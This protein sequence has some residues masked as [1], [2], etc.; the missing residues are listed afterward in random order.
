MVKKLLKFLG[1]SLFFILALMA[2]IPKESV[3]FLLEKELKN[4]EVVI[5]KESLQ[6]NLFSLDITNLEVSAKGIDSAL[7]QEAQI[8]LLLLS[9]TVELSNIKLSS[10]VESYLPSK[11][12]YFQ[13]NYSVLNPFNVT[14]VSHGGFGE[15]EASFDLSSGALE[16]RLK[17]SKKMLNS[18]RSSL[19]KFKKSDNGEY[20]YAKT[21]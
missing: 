12:E 1:L 5:S 20:V 4:F 19:R 15:A 13:A 16:V 6:E 8:T 21:F 17:P 18:Y 9:N 10:L 2:F 7:V 11:I 3:Y 14:A